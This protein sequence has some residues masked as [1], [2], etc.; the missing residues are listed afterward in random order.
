MNDVPLIETQGSTRSSGATATVT[1]S[2]SASTPGEPHISWT[3]SDGS[4]VVLGADDL[5][6]YISL[7]QT[8]L[9]LYVTY[10]EVVGE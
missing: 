2:I 8:L 9:L 1:D 6:V 4:T 3:R 7:L 10:R 5:M